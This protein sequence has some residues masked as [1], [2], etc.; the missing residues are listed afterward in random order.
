MIRFACSNCSR[1]I[2]VDE[3]HSGKKGKCPKCGSVAVVPERSTI[4][5]FSCGSC[6]RKISVPE[7]QG[8]KKGA[9]PKCKNPVV[10]PPLKKVPAESD[11][12][13]PPTTDEDID[14][15][16]L[17]EYEEPEGVD[18][19]LIVLISAVAVIA[20]VGIIIL[21]VVLRPSWAPEHVAGLIISI[22]IV[23][24]V[25]VVLYFRP[26]RIIKLLEEYAKSE[27]VHRRLIPLIAAVA[28]IFGGA[29]GLIFLVVV[30]QPS[31]PPQNVALP[32]ISVAFV[33]FVMVVL[34]FGRARI[35]KRKFRKVE[36]KN[37]ASCKDGEMVKIIG[38]LKYAE[39]PLFAPL[40]KRKCAAYTIIVTEYRSSSVAKWIKIINDK[41]CTPFFLKNGNDY[42]LIKPVP[43]ELLLSKDANYHS[44]T[45]NEASP[46]FEDYINRFGKKSKSMFCFINKQMRYKE[47]VLKE[48]EMVAVLGKGKWINVNEMETLDISGIGKAE[49]LLVIEQ[50]DEDKLYISDEPGIVFN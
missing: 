40:S 41:N 20:V 30:L 26:A 47:G 25:M 24:F 13:I 15:E 34:Y 33:I 4:I 23:I 31:W 5:E 29:V 10:V 48:G 44:G 1:L 8:G 36:E 17:E 18:R 43:S 19:R 3:K 16:S 45:F 11:T 9:C 6:G 2:S 37:I 28:V 21:V 32:I 12:S 46:C 27:R 14:R 39:K 22:A 42:A 50:L 7:R 35:I 49:K 38:E